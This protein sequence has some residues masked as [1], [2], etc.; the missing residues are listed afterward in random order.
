MVVMK[1]SSLAADFAA[2]SERAQ[3]SAVKRFVIAQSLVYQMGTNVAQHNPE[4][5][6]G[7]AAD[8]MNS[9]HPLVEGA[10]CIRR[11][12]LNMDQR[13]VYFSMCPKKTMRPSA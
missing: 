9:V 4:E 7:E 10:H 1:A 6:R 12:I 5:V 3:F 2:K 8:Y 13:L 11:F